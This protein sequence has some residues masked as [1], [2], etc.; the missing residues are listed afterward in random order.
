MHILLTKFTA[1]D[2]PLNVSRETLQSTK[3]LK[4]IKQ[5]LL[6]RL[7]QMFERISKEDPAKFDEI[8]KVFGGA[9]KLGAIED[10]R[11]QAK[12]VPL[13]RWPTNQR[14]F[15]SL[16]DVSRSGRDKE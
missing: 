8:S 13:V 9:I 2:L 6:R 16:D 15:T 5:I 4:Q 3:F 10:R 12:L 7:I 11:N 14:N 1:D